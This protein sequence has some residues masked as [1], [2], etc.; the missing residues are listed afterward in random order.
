MISAAFTDYYYVNTGDCSPLVTHFSYEE[1]N[2]MQKLEGPSIQ[3]YLGSV[4]LGRDLYSRI[5][6]GT[7]MSLTVGFFTA[8]FAL[9]VGTFTGAIAGYWGGWVDNLLMRV[10]DLFYIFP[11]I[12][13][14]ILLMLYLDGE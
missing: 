11:S 4:S 5:I 2:I 9:I 7:R 13:L 10:V 6:Y 1:Q 14:A 12:L 8:L 3:R